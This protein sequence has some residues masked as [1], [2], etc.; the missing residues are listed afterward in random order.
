MRP[1]NRFLAA[2]PVAAL[3]VAM[4]AVPAFADPRDFSVTNN[5]SFIVTNVYA[6]TSDSDTWGDDILGRDVLA[7]SEAVNVTFPGFDGTQCLYDVKI[8][9]QSGQVGVMYKVNLCY[10]SDVSFYDA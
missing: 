7:P 10:Y 4:F 2:I 3:L 5:T 9:G 1:F 8:L 6:G